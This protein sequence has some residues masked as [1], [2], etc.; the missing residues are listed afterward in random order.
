MVRI[1]A[2]LLLVTNIFSQEGD[3]FDTPTEQE[4][5]RLES[6]IPSTAPVAVVEA[7]KVVARERRRPGTKKQ[8]SKMRL[9]PVN[10][11]AQQKLNQ[12]VDLLIEALLLAA[13]LAS[14]LN[15]SKI[16]ATQP[17]I[18]ITKP[19]AGLTHPASPA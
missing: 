5:I 19:N 3:I 4:T 1:L 13:R 7:F 17:I 15:I 8:Y 12:K 18:P 11:T 10:G 16:I 6:T 14:P 9:N 2:V